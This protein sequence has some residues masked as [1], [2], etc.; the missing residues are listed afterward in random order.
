MGAGLDV[1]QENG[2]SFCAR[3]QDIITLILI[4]SYTKLP[5]LVAL[6]QL[7]LILTN[8]KENLHFLG[9]VLIIF[10]VCVIV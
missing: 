9:K 5:R 3:N 2:I 4:I 7:L 6:L 1:L 8:K 10:L